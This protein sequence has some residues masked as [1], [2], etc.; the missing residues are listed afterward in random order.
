MLGIVV[1]S[2]AALLT[3][4]GG[5]SSGEGD[6]T[7][8]Y[9][10]QVVTAAFP[11]GQSLGQTSLL[12][13][14]IRNTGDK[15]IP[16]LAVTISV[17]GGEGQASTLPFGFRDPQPGLAQPDRPVWVL[18]AGYPKRAGDPSP[19]GATTSNAKTFSLGALKPGATTEW[20]WKVSAVEAGA[21]T[22]LYRVGAGLN[23][24]AKVKTAAGVVPGGS[25]AVNISTSP[26]DTIVTDSGEVVPIGKA[27]PQK[28]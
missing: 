23:G 21:H 9:H 3:A 19:G 27:K 25:F 17:E 18:A 11:T 1:A 6:V 10:A 24:A 28:P 2:S 5:G 14:G 16:T 13:L 7:G 15:K 20:V 26:P 8:T 22:L 12:R 4:C